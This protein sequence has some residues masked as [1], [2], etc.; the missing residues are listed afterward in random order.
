MAIVELNRKVA[1]AGELP[2]VCVH[3]GAPA[4]VYRRRSFSGRTPI[5]FT[6]GLGFLRARLPVCERHRYYTWMRMGALLGLVAVWATLLFT[7]GSL[8][9]KPNTPAFLAPLAPWRGALI[10]AC[11]ASMGAIIVARFVTFYTDVRLY[12][13]SWDTMWLTGVS[14]AFADAWQQWNAR[15][16][17]DDVI[18]TP[19][20]GTVATAPVTNA[21]VT[22]RPLT[23]APTSTPTSA[24]ATAAIVDDDDVVML[25]DAEDRAA[26][27]RAGSAHVIPGKQRLVPQQPAPTPTPPT[28]G[29]VVGAPPA[30]GGLSTWLLVCIIGV[31]LCCSLPGA[32][33]LIVAR[34]DDT[35]VNIHSVQTSTI[36]AGTFLRLGYYNKRVDPQANY[37]V[38]VRQNGRTV[39]EQNVSGAA[40]QKSVPIEFGVISGPFGASGKVELTIEEVTPDGGRQ[41]VSNLRTV[42][43]N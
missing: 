3:C 22:N 2:A 13:A 38:V 1:A 24:P 29:G 27:P 41:R 20:T 16:W 9:N 17:V 33:W 28:V 15:T 10:L 5:T 30:R 21:P 40:L 4:V 37:V 14:D 36:G 19:A 7:V 35:K 42:D 26:G 11:V 23:N 6:A 25:V 18:R 34:L 31:C 39:L 32:A 8:D 12:G 43:V